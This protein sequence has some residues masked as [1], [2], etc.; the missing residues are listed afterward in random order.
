MPIKVPRAISFYI[1]L[2]IIG[3][4][5]FLLASVLPQNIAPHV[6]IIA[7]ALGGLL[8]VFYI[9]YMKK[10]HSKFV[11][12]LGSDCSVVIYSRYAKFFGISLE[13]LG[14]AYYAIIF[15]FYTLWIVG[16][17]FITPSL[18]FFVIALT[19]GAFLFS[20]YLIF[21]QAFV[22]RQWCMWCLL[23]SVFSMT[24]FIIS[25]SQI[26]VA[27]SFLV[28]IFPI[29]TLVHFLGFTFGVGGITIASF[30]FFKFLRD[31]R[32][33]NIELSI[34]RTISKVVWFAL[35]IIL[36]SQFALYMPQIEKFNSSEPF[37]IKMIALFVVVITGA[38]LNLIL[39]PYL[40]VIPFREKSKKEHSKFSRMRK[41]VFIV[42]GISIASW[43]AAFTLAL[44]Q[45]FNMPFGNL[46]VIYLVVLFIAAFLSMVIE[47]II[48][49]GRLL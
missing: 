5:G 17:Q 4:S 25:V 26:S 29:L 47:R 33:S 48:S 43:Y 39:S 49:R 31:F 19:F 41:M 23:L 21:I 7:I 20:L 24:I 37:L 28:S 46:A 18:T 27:S 35:I 32:I 3:F 38:I 14:A 9:F 36:L 45:D 44:I 15:S 40:S 11:C 42:G 1:S 13:Y 30:L 34:L 10:S 22:L 12:P 2:L 16:S 8:I 6:F